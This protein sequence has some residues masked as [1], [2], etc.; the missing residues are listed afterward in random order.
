MGDENEGAMIKK[1]LPMGFS[2]FML[3]RYMHVWRN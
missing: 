2:I 3:L 1:H